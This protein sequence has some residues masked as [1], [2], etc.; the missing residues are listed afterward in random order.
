MQ[1]SHEESSALHLFIPQLLGLTVTRIRALNYLHGGTQNLPISPN[2]FE[3]ATE[4]VGAALVD[5]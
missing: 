5:S 1:P 2:E 4:R 3:E